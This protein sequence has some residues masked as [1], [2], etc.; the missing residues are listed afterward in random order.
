[1]Q[2]LGSLA[3][4]ALSAAVQ[5]RD[6]LRRHCED[7]PALTSGFLLD[8][9]RLVVVPIGLESCVRAFTG[10]GSVCRR[11]FPGIRQANRADE[12][13]MC[14]ARTA[15][16]ARWTRFW[17]QLPAINDPAFM[18]T[19]YP[20]TPDN[21]PAW[22]D[23]AA[24]QL[25]LAEIAGLTPWDARCPRETTD[26]SCRLAART[27]RDGNFGGTT[28]SGPDHSRPSRRLTFCV[29]PGSSMRS[30]VCGSYICPNQPSNSR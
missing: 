12:C 23:A 26:T 2:K 15:D 5:K 20:G 16:A 9:A 17:I 25:P 6:F 28:A 19:R 3:R 30:F 10:Q 11:R 21:W 27:G 8:R 13:W 18:T 29:P 7:R 22:P 1:M 24:D 14:S 4:M